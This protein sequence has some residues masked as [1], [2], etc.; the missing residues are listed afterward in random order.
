[1]SCLTC[2]DSDLGEGPIDQTTC[3]PTELLK[4]SRVQSEF[5][6]SSSKQWTDFL[7]T[8]P[9]LTTA[10]K[11]ERYTFT[12]SWFATSECF[13]FLLALLEVTTLAIQSV[14]LFPCIILYMQVVNISF[15]YCFAYWR[16]KPL[17]I[18]LSPNKISWSL[19][20]RRI[21]WRLIAIWCLTLCQ[22]N[23]G[24]PSKN[25]YCPEVTC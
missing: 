21:Y 4:S 8:F 13:W 15:V 17:A 25:V 23:N 24:I 9:A 20:R 14:Y 6:L 2:L 10:F 16:R 11:A 3:Q 19:R 7:A 22:H 18:N 12:G 5:S 1:M